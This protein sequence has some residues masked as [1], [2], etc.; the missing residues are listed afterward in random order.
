MPLDP[1]SIE[2]KDLSSCL[3]REIFGGRHTRGSRGKD[4][5]L[6]ELT[7][8]C[9]ELEAEQLETELSIRANCLFP[10]TA[11]AAKFD[12]LE[13]LGIPHFNG[14]KEVQRSLNGLLRCCAST[15][16]LPGNID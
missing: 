10:F 9:L 1:D 16:L 11:G 2:L 13:I 7:L 5:V 6:L 3:A 4:G 8:E 15:K 12:P 14:K